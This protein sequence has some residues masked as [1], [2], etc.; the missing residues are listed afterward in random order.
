MDWFKELFIDEA[1]NA[2]NKH[3]SAGG[4]EGSGGSEGGSI[5][6]N[7]L[8]QI[9]PIEAKYIDTETIATKTYVEELIGGIE[10]GSY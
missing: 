2:L 9:V 1:K 3:S 8:T 4:S 5:G 6:W 7:D 10:N